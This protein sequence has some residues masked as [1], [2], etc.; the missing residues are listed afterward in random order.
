MADKLKSLLTSLYETKGRNLGKIPLYP[1][2]VK[3]EIP[4]VPPF[5]KGGIRKGDL[6]KGKIKS[7]C[8]HRRSDV[9]SEQVTSGG[10]KKRGKIPSNPPLIKGGRKW[11]DLKEVIMRNHKKIVKKVFSPPAIILIVLLAV[12]Y[13]TSNLGA[14]GVHSFRKALPDTGQTTV[15]NSG[16][17]DDASYIKP[18]PQ[19]AYIDNGDGTVTDKYTGLMWMKCSIGQTGSSC[20]GSASTFNWSSAISTCEALN[21]AGYSDWRLPNMKELFSLI[22][23]EG[24]SG[25]YIDT[26]YFPNTVSNYYW[27]STT[28]LPTTTAA[29]YV[30]FNSGDVNYYFKTSN[31]YVRCVRAGP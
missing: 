5:K 9:K 28:Y 27:T 25:P 8:P 11:G 1:P 24:S 4:S 3:G 10:E 21:F 13:G 20:S 15:Y 29:M 23:F 26:T 17:G 16:G 31:F 2:L 14:Q 30:N 22:K 12:C 7:P 6:I 18:N 19:M